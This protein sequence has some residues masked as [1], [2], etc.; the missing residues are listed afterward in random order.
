MNDLRSV[1][2]VLEG[3][4]TDVHHSSMSLEEILSWLDEALSDLRGI[5]DPAA[6]RT[7]SSIREASSTLRQVV[8]SWFPDYTKR[9]EDLNRRITA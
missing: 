2:I 8:S 1:T 9:T 7:E 4:T 5:A 3:L 6:R